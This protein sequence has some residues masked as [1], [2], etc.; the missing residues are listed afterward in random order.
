MRFEG[1]VAIVTGGGAGL[2][3]AYVTALC[4]EGA[5]V[6]I[7]E[8]NEESGRKLEQELL[9]ADKKALFVKTNVA[10]EDNIKSMVEETIKAYGRIDILINNAQATDSSNL[11]QL[12]ENTTLS[13][14]KTCWETGFL[15]T[16]FATKYVLPYMKQQ[17]YGRIINTASGTGVKGMETFSAYGSQ[18]EAIRGLTR[19]TAQE[20]GQFGITCNVICPGAMTDASRSWAATDPE[21]Y[22]AAVAPQPIKRMGDPDTDIAPAVLFFASEESRFV[23]GQT[24][25]LDGGT[26][27]F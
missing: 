27:R 24:I 13:L 21:G 25:G 7:A 14:V 22:A 26:T 10:N 17:G 12:I 11:P 9:A 4:K 18:K 2:G 3:K 15:G 23:T 16:F 20:Y 5:S 6:V 8:Y 19:V 1:R